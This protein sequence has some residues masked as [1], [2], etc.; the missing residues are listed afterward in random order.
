MLKDAEDKVV[1]EEKEGEG[2]DKQEKEW[3]ENDNEEDDEEKVDD[4]EDEQADEDEEQDEDH[5]EQDEDHDGEEDGHGADT[6]QIDQLHG[7][8]SSPVDQLHD[9]ASSPPKTRGSK[10]KATTQIT[11]PTPSKKSKTPNSP[12]DLVCPSLASSRHLSDRAYRNTTHLAT[13]V[14]KP[15]PHVKP[16]R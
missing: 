15:P 6:D 11:P 2:K 4:E 5:E 10:R 16:G 14:P 3:E 9:E 13:T 8:A 1:E 12:G 7:D